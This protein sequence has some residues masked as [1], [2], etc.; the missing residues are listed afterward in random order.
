MYIDNL[1]KQLH[2]MQDWIILPPW[3]IILIIVIVFLLGWLFPV[4]GPFDYVYDKY[5]KQPAIHRPT[6]GIPAP[7]P[8]KTEIYADY[9]EDGEPEWYQLTPMFEIRVEEE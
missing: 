7:A 6:K 8:K 5:A 1:L 2:K 9:N 3:V 4:E